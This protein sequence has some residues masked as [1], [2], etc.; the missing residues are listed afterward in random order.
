MILHPQ[1]TFNFKLF[2]FRQHFFRWVVTCVFSYSLGIVWSRWKKKVMIRF[3]LSTYFS[4][5]YDNVFCGPGS[6]FLFVVMNFRTDPFLLVSIV[7]ICVTVEIFR[8]KVIY[9][10]L[11]RTTFFLICNMFHA[12]LTI[13]HMPQ[14]SVIH[15]KSQIA[16]I[17]VFTWS[18]LLYDGRIHVQQ[19]ILRDVP[20]VLRILFNR[21]YTEKFSCNSDSSWI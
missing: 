13:V 7:F 17:S 5:I 4:I 19:N 8:I 16:L 21:E 6:D 11:S 18:E 10:I 1:T 12:I 2:H 20:K 9:V 14:P 3:L 15:R